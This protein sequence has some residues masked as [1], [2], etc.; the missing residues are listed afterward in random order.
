[1]VGCAS[2]R[3]SLAG[4]NLGRQRNGLQ[5][6]SLLIQQD[7]LVSDQA[8]RKNARSCKI[9]TGKLI[10]QKSRRSCTKVKL[11]VAAVASPTGSCLRLIGLIDPRSGGLA[12]YVKARITNAKARRCAVT[13]FSVGYADQHADIA[14][15]QNQVLCNIPVPFQSELCIQHC[16]LR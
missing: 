11:G 3:G 13:K 1:M 15:H 7:L 8:V 6:T 9:T 5:R 16:D 2:N 12:P 4:Y 14:S 10:N